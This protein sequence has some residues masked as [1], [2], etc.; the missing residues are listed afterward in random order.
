MTIII[1]NL[2]KGDQLHIYSN[3]YIYIYI[4]IY[5]FTKPFDS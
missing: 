1:I 3:I 2:V 4:Y 5:I